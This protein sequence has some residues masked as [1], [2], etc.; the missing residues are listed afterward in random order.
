MPVK[1]VI[2]KTW[3]GTIANSADPDDA[4][5]NRPTSVVSAL[6]KDPF[7]L[8]NRHIIIQERLNKLISGINTTITEAFDSL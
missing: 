4:E 5:R 1:R 7:F 8:K 3:T 2:F 6:I